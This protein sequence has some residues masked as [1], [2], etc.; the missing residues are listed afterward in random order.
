MSDESVLLGCGIDRPDHGFG[1]LEFLFRHADDGV[2]GTEEAEDGASA[3]FRRGAQ[4][5]GGFGGDGA[6][7]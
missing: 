4:G 5:A 7:R 1:L 6:E 3:R 2:A